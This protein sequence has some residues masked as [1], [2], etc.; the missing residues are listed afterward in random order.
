MIAIRDILI[1]VAGGILVYVYYL[2]RNYLY[3]KRISVSNLM[4]KEEPYKSRKVSTKIPEVDTARFNR[5][6]AQINSLDE[7]DSTYSRRVKKED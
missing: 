2:T 3:G 5:I 7:F 1:F 4:Q 6:I